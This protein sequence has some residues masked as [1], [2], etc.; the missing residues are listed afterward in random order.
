MS[1]RTRH[2]ICL[3]IGGALALLFLW[4]ITGCEEKDDWPGPTVTLLQSDFEAIVERAWANDKVGQMRAI[5]ETCI[6]CHSS[7]N[8]PNEVIWFEADNS[9]INLDLDDEPNLVGLDGEPNEIARL[10]IDVWSKY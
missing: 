8:G 9:H 1:A 4:V 5:S 7:C 2:Y 3:L 10:W 6:S